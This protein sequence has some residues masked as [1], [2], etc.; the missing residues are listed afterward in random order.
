VCNHPFVEYIEEDQIVNMTSPTSLWHLDRIDQSDLPLDRQYASPSNGTGVDIYIFDTGEQIIMYTLSM[1]G[2]QTNAESLNRLILFIK[3]AYG[4]IIAYSGIRYDH[5]EFEGRAKYDFYDPVDMVTGS[6]QQGCDCQGHGTH[7]AALAA[8]KTFG[9][10]KGATVYSTRVLSC[11]G[12]GSFANVILGLHHVIRQ[13]MAQKERKIIVSMSL[14]GPT[15]RAVGEVIKD[16]TDEGLL[17]VVAA[18]NDFS[19]ACRY[20][21]GKSVLFLYLYAHIFYQH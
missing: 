18:G 2:K 1:E 19:D 15:S 20:A 13:K 8:G 7:V 4:M 17:V 10:A 12:S 9:A 16:A 5:N 11:S 14:R 3:N 6:N 21:S